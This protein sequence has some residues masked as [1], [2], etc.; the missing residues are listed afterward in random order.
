M[1]DRTAASQPSSG[2]ALRRWFIAGVVG[3]LVVL[4]LPSIYDVW[5]VNVAGIL[6]NRAIVVGADAAA[7]G[8]APAKAGSAG[9]SSGEAKGVTVV[10]AGG[11]YILTPQAETLLKLS[12]ALMEAAASRGPH[13]AAR[14]VPIWRTYGAAARM[15][16]SDR[17][18]ELLER[19][20]NA[21]RLD[22][23]GELWLGEVASATGNWD[24]AAEAYG[25]VDVSNLLV[26]RAEAHIHA[27]QKDLALRELALAKMS[28]D[29]LADRERA[30][31]LLLDRTGNQP[32]ALA[33]MLQRPAERATTLSRIGAALLSLGQ[34][35]QAEP[36]LEQ[37]LALAGSS[38]PGVTVER[39]LR[40]D[41]ASAL[42]QTLPEAPP[43]AT[44]AAGYSYFPGGGE[45]AYLKALIRI[46]ALV[47]QALDLERTAAT[48]T[49]AGGI[50]MRAGDEGPAVSLLTEAT[51]LDP[52]F[53]DPYLALGDWYGR[54]QMEYLARS[55]YAEAAAL[56]PDNSLIASALAVSTFATL[57]HADALLLLL[58]AVEMGTN[59]PHVFAF[60]GDCY[61]ELGQPDEARAAW[62]EGLRLFPQTS[63][64]NVRLAS[65]GS[66]SGAG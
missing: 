65:L 57:P 22:W 49:R 36:V 34:P 21:G 37:G 46:R 31:L 18:F 33:G 14:E 51:R 52:L 2:G 41:L 1:I 20:R 27:G 61:Q 15:L 64:L 55:L 25:R 24:A 63:Y 5:Q 16:P 4:A 38:P 54:H 40:L 60:L 8:K 45:P 59:D 56:M 19:S 13:T 17:T 62:Q 3:F 44:E 28:L 30:K 26:Y 48:C 47:S 32:S 11:D 6:L 7:Q 53:A 39:S 9:S 29:A 12:L 58:R 10:G 42:A 66:T 43:A 50:L 23:Y 35:A